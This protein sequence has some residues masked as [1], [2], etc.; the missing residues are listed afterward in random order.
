MNEY[1]PPIERRIEIIESQIAECQTLIYRNNVENLS[2][3]VNGEKSKQKEVEYNN[4]TLKEKVDILKE[5]LGRLLDEDSSN[6]A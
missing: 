5:E 6:T 2:F 4:E 3:V 1:L